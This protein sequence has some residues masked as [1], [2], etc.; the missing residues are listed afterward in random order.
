ME[1][2]KNPILE[3]YKDKLT[4]RSELNEPKTENN[5]V[6]VLKNLKNI[7][8]LNLQELEQ[9]QSSQVQ[10]SN[11][12]SPI[13]SPKEG[14]K[15]RIGIWFQENKLLNND[16]EKNNDNNSNIMS[17]NEEEKNLITKKENK[18]LSELKQFEF[19]LK[20]YF[21]M[22]CVVFIT[23]F[24]YDIKMICLNEKYKFF[25]NIIYILAVIYYFFD[26]L[27]RTIINENLSKTLNYWIDV[28]SF[29]NLFFDFD[30]I[31]Y[32]LLQILI[33][34]KESRKKKYISYEEQLTIEMVLNIIQNFRLLRVIKLYN[35]FVN[36]LKE[37]E[38][39]H[40][41][42]KYIEKIEK[43]IRIPRTKSNNK[44]FRQSN[45]LNNNSNMNNTSTFPFQTPS[46]HPL[47]LEP[48][49]NKKIKNS[50]FSINNNS[51]NEFKKKGVAIEKYIKEHQQSR[52]SR[53]ITEGISRIMIFLVLL[54]FVVSIFTDEDNYNN[55][56]ISY[57][58]LIKYSIEF[59]DNY[60]VNEGLNLVK[61]YFNSTFSLNPS[62]LYCIIWVE[63][64][65]NIV[66]ENKSINNNKN[67][68]HKRE[69][70][71]IYPRENNNTIIVISRK[72]FSQIFSLMYIGKLLYIVLSVSFLCFWINRDINILIFEP[73]EKIGKVI[74]IVS[75]D[76]VNSKTIEELKNN[77]EKVGIKR[78]DKES[79]SH[80]IRIIQ[81]A[82]IRI[83]ALIAISFGEAGGEILKENIQSSEGL[84][85]MLS[86]E[87]IQAIFG[88]CYIHN[89]SEINEVFQEK[90]MIFVN[91]ISNIVHS[92]V[93]K[94]NG[95][96][97]KNLGDS[98]LLTWK[99]KD[100]NNQKKENTLNENNNSNNKN[101]NNNKNND[102]Q[103]SINNI[104]NN[105][106]N[107]QNNNIVNELYDKKSE[108]ADCAL[109][110][111]LNILKK[112]NKSRTIL[113]YRKDPDLIKK[114]G[115]KYSVQMG[116]GLHTGWGIEGAIGSFY[117]I[118]CSY[119]SPNVNIAARL[120]TA[121]NIYGVNILF[122]GEFYNLL[123]D[124]MKEKCRKIDIVTLKGSEK[125]VNLYTVDINKN[126]RPGKLISNKERLNLREKRNYYA[127]K[128][129]KLWHKY[130]KV[131]PNKTIGEVYMKQSKGL[132][133]LLKPYKSNLFFTYF[134]DGFNDYIDGEWEDAYQNL[135][136]AK[137]LDKSDGP[138]KTILE[139][140]KSYKC[141]APSNWDGYRILTSKT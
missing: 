6:N 59:F 110:G 36:F 71:Y 138:T 129:K 13:N 90:T 98:F 84:N 91:Q 120:E 35:L 82:I 128:K 62:H 58:F 37:R 102:L 115:N 53:K 107:S 103:N 111:F 12:D 78:E 69:I 55:N 45:T 76:P 52:I 97:N 30:E 79:V 25:Y 17:N 122:S 73:L 26:F 133:Q 50:F 54:I 28:F 40:L 49:K 64:K 136:K 1:N 57:Y 99:F 47:Y 113:Q 89:F 23:I 11:N 104:K 63:W 70:S 48:N 77:V 61:E 65:E 80:E 74:D 15:R 66:Y 24:F 108:L 96:T 140:I 29:L 4:K 118:D 86:G 137:Y 92:C 31:S 5:Q 44:L 117:K 19:S 125:P 94:F 139:Y 130:S 67:N 100:N 21:I 131:K 141:Q 33:Y 75:K 46:P 41:I 14:K 95:I 72:Y 68:Y 27:L 39:N 81:S 88:F 112:I 22:I 7:N 32:P 43:K 126:I 8:L 127:T 34:G 119:L 116:F 83:S 56:T 135:L 85:P 38:N 20:G 106:T 60:T 16:N 134:E 87:K 109:L 101:N 114:F 10:S 121:T 132:R 42:Q 18:F 3:I 105:K 93:D 2:N 9:I 51:T 124:F 123:S